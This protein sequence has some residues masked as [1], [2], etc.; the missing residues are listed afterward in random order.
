M[1]SVNNIYSLVEDWENLVRECTVG[2]SSNVYEFDYDF[3]IR[4]EIAEEVCSL[5][6]DLYEQAIRRIEPIDNEFLKLL[7]FLDERVE[8]FFWERKFV[9]EFGSSEYATSVLDALKIE[10]KVV[11]SQ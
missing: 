11:D 4:T 3:K 7:L 8:I 5:D 1:R 9:L 2:Y 6:G 10:I